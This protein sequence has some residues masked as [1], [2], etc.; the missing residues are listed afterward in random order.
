M[1]TVVVAIDG[2][3]G[4][5]KSTTAQG[6]AKKLG[7]FYLDTGAMYRAFTLNLIRH[8]YALDPAKVRQVVLCS[9][10]DIKKDNGRYR[11]LLNGEDVSAQIRTPEVNEKVSQVSALPLVRDLL[12]GR[13]RKMALGK[14]IVCEG[15]DI[16]TVVFPDADVKI[17]MHADIK[18]RA[19]RR[20]RE[21]REKHLSL[22]PMVPGGDTVAPKVIREFELQE[23]EKS[24]AFRDD[25]DSQRVHSPLR[26]A[27]GAIVIDTTNLTI[28]EE[29]ELAYEHVLKRLPPELQPK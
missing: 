6:L 26:V 18:V 27:E 12:V 4:S 19:Q 25:Y 9:I 16:G 21:F 1:H 10:I 15:R 13:Q 23:V 22:R 24:L 28:E 11:I 17:Y 7:F 8:G 29:I 2:T 3:A 5:G 20:L 14:S